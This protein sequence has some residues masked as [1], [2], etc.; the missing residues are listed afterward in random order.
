MAFK[1]RIRLLVW[2]GRN[3]FHITKKIK[4]PMHMKRII[5]LEEKKVIIMNS[6]IEK[7]INM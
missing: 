4:D 5:K 7:G 3:I 6:K 1:P 2:I